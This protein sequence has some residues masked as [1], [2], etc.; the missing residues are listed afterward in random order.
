[1]VVPVVEP[2]AVVPIH[3]NGLAHIKTAG[4]AMHFTLYADQLSADGETMERIVV[5]RVI[6][7][8]GGVTA[9]LPHVIASLPSMARALVGRQDFASASHMPH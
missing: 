2:F 8:V 9:A 3:A 1:M 5:A 4:D 6:I 7:P